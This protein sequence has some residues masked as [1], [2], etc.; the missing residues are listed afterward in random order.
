[1]GLDVQ[2]TTSHGADSATLASPDGSPD[3]HEERGGDIF[4]DRNRYDSP[5]SSIDGSTLAPRIHLTAA[6]VAA[7]GEG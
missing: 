2:V 3:A 7:A 6:V 1:M 4:D 5:S